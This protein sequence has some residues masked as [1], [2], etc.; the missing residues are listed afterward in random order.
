MKAT[1]AGL[2]LAAIFGVACGG[3]AAAGV[4]APAARDAQAV[5]R[6]DLAPTGHLRLG[7][8]AAPPFLGQQDP[9]SGRWKGLAISLGNSLAAKLGVSLVPVVYADPE[10]AYRALLAGQV[11]VVLGPVQAKP[12]GTAGTVPAV[13]V[14]HTYLVRAGSALQNVSDVDRPGIRV[15]SVAGSPHTA[16]LSAHLAHATLVQFATDADALAALAAGHIDAYANVRLALAGLMSKV[17]GSR[18]LAGTFLDAGFGFV[19]PSSRAKGSV[20]LNSFVESEVSSGQLQRLVQAI[21]KPGVL[22]GP[23]A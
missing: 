6:A 10:S 11:D 19:I 5:A 2:G 16:F 15:G 3:T 14:E 23:A 9:S 8:P 13:S 22:A 12:D 20:F 4:N 7:F 21:D 18:M 17:P 1:L